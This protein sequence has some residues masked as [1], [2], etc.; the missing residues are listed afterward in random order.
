MNLVRSILEKAQEDTRERLFVYGTLR[1][2]FPLHEVLEDSEFVDSG[3]IEGFAMYRIG[4][5]PTVEESGD[6]QDKVFGEIYLISPKIL[7]KIDDV[8]GHPIVYKRTW[9]NQLGGVW[10]Y[11]E[12]NMHP[13]YYENKV[14]DGIYK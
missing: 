14:E 4:D 3:W 5:V 1:E 10:V 8:E 6:S 9:V 13:S 12:M 7:Q 2:G 11:L